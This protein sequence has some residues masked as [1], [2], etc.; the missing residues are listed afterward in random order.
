MSYVWNLIKITLCVFE[1]VGTLDTVLIYY[2]CKFL[3]CFEK[4]FFCVALAVLELTL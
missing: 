2:K 3:F 1:T 4:G